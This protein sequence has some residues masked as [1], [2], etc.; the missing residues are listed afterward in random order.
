MLSS[1][2]EERVKKN[3]TQTD[4]MG[5]ETITLGEQEVKDE[6]PGLT[7]DYVRMCIHSKRK[8]C[9]RIDSLNQL[10]NIH[11]FTNRNSNIENTRKVE[12][13]KDSV[14]NELRKLL[15]KEYEWIKTRKRLMEGNTEGS[16]R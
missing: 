8:V 7:F 15:P 1:V 14:F 12:V 13:P 9:L 6:L 10:Q 2:I 3:I 5:Y 16:S 11:D 4:N